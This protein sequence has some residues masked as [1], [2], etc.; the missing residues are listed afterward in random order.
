[1]TFIDAPPAD[2]SAGSLSSLLLP[3]LPRWWARSDRWVVIATCAS[4]FAVGILFTV[5][6]VSEVV[7]RYLFDF[8][9]SQADSI[10]QYLLVWFFL[11][12]ASLAMRDR[13]HVGFELLLRRM[14]PPLSTVAFIVAQAMTLTFFMIMLRSGLKVV[15]SSILEIEGATGVPLV[16]VMAAFPVGFVMLIYTQAATLVSVL[17]SQAERR[18]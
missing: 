9:I 18:T 10:A 12:G 5:L 6:I 1:V 3:G 2:T 8:S 17:R 11:L 7:S 13:A 16:W 14:R 15:P 4:L